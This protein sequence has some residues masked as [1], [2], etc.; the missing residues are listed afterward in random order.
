MCIMILTAK[1][2][3]QPTPQQRQLLDSRLLKYDRV[4]QTVSIWTVSGRQIVPSIAA[5]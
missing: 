1:I 2:K 5:W 3:L 4:A